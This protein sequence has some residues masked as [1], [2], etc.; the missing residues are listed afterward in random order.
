MLLGRQHFE[1]PFYILFLL[2]AVHSNGDS[3]LEFHSVPGGTTHV[4]HSRLIITCR[5][6]RSS[7]EYGVLTIYRHGKAVTSGHRSVQT[8]FMVSRAD[9]QVALFCTAQKSGETISVKLTFK[10]INRGTIFILTDT[11]TTAQTNK[12]H[13]I[14]ICL[15]H[16][17]SIPNKCIQII[18]LWILW[19]NKLHY[20]LPKSVL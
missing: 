5:L 13:W 11:H 18:E 9:H 19:L 14:F 4:E 8:D 10:V 2:F 12:F 15:E 1:I 7:N 16:T 17:A 3:I 6:K 20:I